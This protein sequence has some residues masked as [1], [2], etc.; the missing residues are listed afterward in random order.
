MSP[1]KAYYVERNRLFTVVKNFPAGMLLMVPMYA[2]LRYFWHLAFMLRGEGAAAEYRQAASGFSL[3]W[4]VVKAHVAALR[5]LPG[6]L[7]SRR[8]IR[9]KARL[10]R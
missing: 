8:A 2:L 7:K 1:L 6:L 3:I 5:N 10:S 9:K 4:F